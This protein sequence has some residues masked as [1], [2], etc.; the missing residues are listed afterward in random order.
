M[1]RGVDNSD[2]QDHAKSYNSDHAGTAGKFCFHCRGG[3]SCHETFLHGRAAD[4]AFLNSDR[5]PMCCE[6][7]NG[8]EALLHRD[9]KVR[10]IEY[11]GES[12][13]RCNTL[14]TIVA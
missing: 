1:V 10:T 13:G 12:E 8:N 14:L 4:A 3:C 9:E 6:A 2:D 11:E 7:A 5:V